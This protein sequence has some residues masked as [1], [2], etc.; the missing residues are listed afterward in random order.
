MDR[1][2]QKSR[3]ST[4]DMNR[5]RVFRCL[6]YGGFPETRELQAQ[7]WWLL[8]MIVVVRV[9]YRSRWLGYVSLKV[10]LTL[11]VF[12]FVNIQQSS[13]HHNWWR[14]VLPYIFS[15]F[16]VW[17]E[18]LRERHTYNGDR[19]QMCSLNVWTLLNFMS[20]WVWVFR[21]I[22]PEIV[23]CLLFGATASRWKV[24]PDLSPL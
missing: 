23:L 1:G 21:A 20:L 7:A 6:P 9:Q 5:D 16:I 10:P 22:T 2:N 15:A 17:G 3:F 12:G 11:R 13:Y 19:R 24:A 18:R 4:S 14:Q 8:N